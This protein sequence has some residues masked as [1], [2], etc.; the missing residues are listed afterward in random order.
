M[1]KTNNKHLIGLLS[2]T[3]WPEDT[4]LDALEWWKDWVREFRPHHI[5]HL[6]DMFN[7]TQL[8]RFLMPMEMAAGFKDSVDSGRKQ[9]ADFDKFL[10]ALGITW[11]LVTGNHGDRLPKYLWRK[12]PELSNMEMFSLKSIMEIP[13]D[14]VVHPMN[15]SVTRDGVLLY[16]G[17]RCSEN[18]TAYNFR[19]G[20]NVAQGHSHRL[21]MKHRRLPGGRVIRSLELGCM[22]NFNPAYQVSDLPD[23]AHGLGYIEDGTLEYIGKD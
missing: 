22:C 23:W 10:R 21:G 2:D 6:G 11:E 20:M 9:V 17:T 13:D 15:T 8:G 1:K 18:L 5:V 7:L 3:H 16:H 14:V 4:N 12:A 19:Y